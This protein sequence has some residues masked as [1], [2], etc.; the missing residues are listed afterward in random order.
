MK[1]ARSLVALVSLAALASLGCTDSDPTSPGSWNTVVATAK[2][3][4]IRIT[5]RTAKP[6]YTATF[7]RELMTRIDWVPC[8][9][10][11]RC[12]P[13]PPGD[14]REVPYPGDAV[15]AGEKEAVVYWWHTR[16]GPADE[17]V[18]DTL[19]WVVVRL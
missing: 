14:T 7:G 2:Y 9:D 5:N 12:P 10:P 6:V 18:P 15:P 8:V 1:R 3:G 11:V 4:R 19:G 17:P 13:I 16:T